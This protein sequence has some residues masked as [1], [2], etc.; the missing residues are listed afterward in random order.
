MLKI[1]LSVKFILLYDVMSFGDFMHIPDGFLDITLSVV[2]FA[3]AVLFWVP[4]FYKANRSI[5]N[6]SI[7]L[8]AV[9]TAGVFAAQMLNFPIIGGTSGHLI[10]ATLISVFLGVFPAVVS[11][12]IILLIQGLVFGDGGLTAL[13]ANS[14]NMAVV[15]VFVGFAFYSLI[16]RYLK[17]D[18]GILAGVFVGSWLSVF[19]AALLCGL[20]IGFSSIF[21]YGVEVTV[22]AMLFWH[23]IIA[24]GEALISVA[25]VGVV[26]RTHPEL[27]PAVQRFSV[28]VEPLKIV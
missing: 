18:R 27:V 12:T 8:M 26:L 9:L 13:G 14:F 24:F 1:L 19:A 22:P 17:G 16:R 6:G 5:N 23:I 10:G 7:P 4:S 21:P 11:V 2:M 28:I 20:E 15:A 25:V 3:L